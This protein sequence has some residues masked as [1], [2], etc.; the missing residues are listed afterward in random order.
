[1]ST[2]RPVLPF[3]VAT[4]LIAGLVLPSAAKDCPVVDFGDDLAWFCQGI[5]SYRRGQADMKLVTEQT[6]ADSFRIGHPFSLDVPLSPVSSEYNV[7]GNNTRFYGGMMT[8]AYNTPNAQTHYT[9]GGINVDHDGF[10]DFN[11]MGYALKSMDNTLRAFGCWIWQKEDFINGGD[12]HPV[13]FDENSRVGVYL[14]RTYAVDKFQDSYAKTR[15]AD[16]PRN[17]WKGWEAVHLIVRDGKQFYIAEEAFQPAEQTLFEVCPTQVKWAKWNP[18]G[19]WS[20]EWDHAGAV[21]EPHTFT[22]VTAVGWMIAKP[23]PT[24]A[25][26]WLKWYSFGM[27]AVVNRPQEPSWNVPML[28]L[29]ADGLWMASGEVTYSQWRKV[30]KWASRNQYSL[31]PG[32][33]FDGDGNMGSMAADQAAHSP[34][35]PVTGITWHDAAVWCNALSEYEGRTPCYYE[36]AEYTKPLRATKNRL[37]LEASK[38]LPAVYFKP[39]TDG[40]RLPTADEF[41]EAV[42]Q[43]G[44][45]CPA[46]AAGTRAVSAGSGFDGLLGNVWE[47]I[48]DVSGL[49]SGKSSE[50]TVLGG[51]FRG[52]AAVPLLAAGEVPSRGHYAIGFR[53]VR[54]EGASASVEPK[55]VSA[56]D[57][58]WSLGNIPAWSFGRDEVIKPAKQIA[59][60]D[61]APAIKTVKMGGFEAGETE[62]T[63]AQWKQVHQ[64]G[65]ANGYR[66]DWDGDMGSMAWSSG[67]EKHIQDEPVTSIGILDAMVWCNALSEMKGY[68]PCYY[69]DKALAEPLRTVNPF[70]VLACPRHMEGKRNNSK[71]GNMREFLFYMNGTADGYRLP[72][73]DEWTAMAGG[74]PQHYPSGETL[75][76]GSAWFD[77]N[78]GETTHPVGQASPTG[79]G[80][81]DLAGNVFEWSLAQTDPDPRNG[82][83]FIPQTHGGSFRSEIGL[84]DAMKTGSISVNRS[85]NWI[86]PGIAKPEIGFR[87]VR[88]VKPAD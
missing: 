4:L 69:A 43:S 81:Y 75:D 5:P 10:D 15:I 7:R 21:F 57:G 67:A 34:D 12:R 30:F 56:K 83:A 88:T 49:D 17:L 37:S 3:A 59:A 41:A 45:V 79:A 23:T 60:A 66:F 58:M 65:E 44:A 71:S 50:R 18:A 6:G 61:M 62:I 28:K 8:L 24:L 74:N 25:G 40:F 54:Q 51:D 48:W 1:M 33:S 80:F 73:T 11:Y 86:N 46:P 47:Y 14:S 70:R 36:D 35:E 29:G 87:I 2:S 26:L 39:D 22:D 77:K 42:K 52:P 16:I 84:V 38:V 85:F 20:F 63:Y 31:H 55:G 82:V 78:S 76:P 68:K 64:W 9:E 27:D 13:T 53:P 19:P 72:M 32:Y